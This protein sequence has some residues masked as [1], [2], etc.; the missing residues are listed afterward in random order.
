M[1][2]KPK[3]AKTLTRGES[4]R[5]NRKIKEPIIAITKG[6]TEGHSLEKAL[7]ML[8]VDKIIKRATR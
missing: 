6:M 4:M 7:D 1:H 3:I 8:P 5:H 2:N